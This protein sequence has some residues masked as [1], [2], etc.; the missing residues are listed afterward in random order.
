MT[1]ST[2]RTSTR[3]FNTGAA[4][5]L[6]L[7]LLLLFSVAAPLNQFKI[8]PIMSVIM[9]ALGISVSSAGLLMSVFAITGLILALPSGFILQRFGF[10]VTGLLA[11]GSIVLGAVLGALSR[12][13]NVLLLSRV[14]E[15]VGT[16][17]VAVL[18][19]AIIARWFGAEKRGAAMGVWSAWVPL[20]TIIMLI[21]APAL[22][23]SSGW[24][25]VWWAGAAYAAVTTALYL[26]FVRPAPAAPA[27]AEPEAGARAADAPADGGLGRVL[28]NRNVWLLSATF[29]AFN[30]S[31]IGFSSYLPTFLAA[32]HGLGLTQA[33]LVAGIPTFLTLISAPVGGAIS[34]R[35]RSRKKP[36]LIGLVC[37]AVLVSLAG[38]TGF[39]LLIAVLVAIGLVLG[40]IPTTI[41]SAAVE[42]T[43][44]VRLG[45]MAMAVVMV[46]QNAGMLL[47]PMIVGALAESSG[48]PLAFISA[49]AMAL[50]GVIVGGLVK[51]R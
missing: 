7:V 20:G 24:Q 13:M 45:G 8:P 25:S 28:R 32:G 5:W 31:L 27:S 11:G 44:D 14:I 49:G 2:T 9:D 22:A 36:F 26:L 47:G 19:P 30:A 39:A 15:G 50:V 29:A 1:Q 16:S 18:A 12:D 40:V 6:I 4:A 46:G 21:V 23:Q 51:V 35:I 17:L 33:A 38:L 41:F 10:K 3:T 42:A 37:S 43:G 48:W 34:D